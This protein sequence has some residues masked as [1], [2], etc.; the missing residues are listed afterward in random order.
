MT[1]QLDAQSLLN[2]LDTSH[3]FLVKRV[4]NRVFG[5]RGHQLQ[6]FVLE[7]PAMH[8][9]VQL[10]CCQSQSRAKCLVHRG[11]KNTSELLPSI[12]SSFMLFLTNKKNTCCLC[13]NR[14]KIQKNEHFF[15]RSIC[16]YKPASLINWIL[17]QFKRKIIASNAKVAVT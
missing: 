7:L 2:G 9:S 3:V 8:C 15:G 5:Q 6:V 13:N 16:E 1:G 14:K 12:S 4:S 17:T 10:N 11:V